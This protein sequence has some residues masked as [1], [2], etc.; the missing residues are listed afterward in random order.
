MGDRLRNARKAAGYGSAT[1]AAEALGI[2]DST[3][4]AHENGQNEFSAEDAEL[5]ARRFGVTA[6][7][8]LLDEP[9]DLD[10]QPQRKEALRTI[11]VMGRLGAGA[12]IEPDYEQ[13]PPDGLEEISLPFQVDDDLI[14]FRVKGESMLPFYKPNTVIVVYREQRK[15]IEA[16]YGDDAAVRTADGRRFIKTVMRGAGRGVNLI[17]WN[18]APME[19]VRLEWIGEIFA[20]LPASAVR[21]VERRGGMQGRLGLRTG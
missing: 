20:T 10:L 21:T 18:A 2:K 3:Y 7:Y 16:F 12:E 17:S 5:Y 9:I 19:N 8:L 13:V 15:P 6:G 14:A 4:R 11:P 1:K